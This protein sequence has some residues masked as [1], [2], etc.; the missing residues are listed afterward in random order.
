MFDI[1]YIVL[2]LGSPHPG[3]H[4]G[5]MYHFNKYEFPTPKDN[6]CQAWFIKSNIAFSRKRWNSYFF[7]LRPQPVTPFG[8]P[9]GPPWE[10][11]WKNIILHRSKKVST[12]KI[13]WLFYL[14]GSGV[15]LNIN[16]WNLHILGPWEPSPWPA[17]GHGYHLN[18]F[19]SPTPKDGL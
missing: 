3:P 6:S 19:E 17:W 12:W 8:S 15:F 5:H 10:L 4:W 16:V 1:L 7:T 18:N 9:M 14:A 11:S 2:A 13:S